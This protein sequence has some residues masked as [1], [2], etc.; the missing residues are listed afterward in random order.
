[1]GFACRFRICPSCRGPQPS[2]PGRHGS[3]RRDG[4]PSMAIKRPVMDGSPRGVLGRQQLRPDPNLLHSCGVFDGKA[5]DSRK[6]D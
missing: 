6:G 1:M 2:R 5:Y 4:T 3:L